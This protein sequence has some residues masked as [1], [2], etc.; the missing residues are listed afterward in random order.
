MILHKKIKF[1]N[2]DIFLFE[3]I[4]GFG[5]PINIFVLF[6]K[7][8]IL[9]IGPNLNNLICIDFDYYISRYHELRV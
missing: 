3:V 8:Y 7:E 2:M 1:R 4:Y 6:F 9:Y 5:F